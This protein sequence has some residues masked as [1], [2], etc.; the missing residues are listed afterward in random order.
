[1][2][3]SVWIEI[4]RWLVTAAGVY[5]AAGCVFAVPFLVR[6]VERI[7]PAAR[8]SSLGF[9]VLVAPGVVALWPFLL[10]RWASGA[11]APR[12]ERNA[13]RER[14]RERRPRT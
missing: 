13:H 8:G 4:V 5:A 10:R 1:M 2:W 9:R 14:A 7:D 11:R 12:E 3:P 6:G